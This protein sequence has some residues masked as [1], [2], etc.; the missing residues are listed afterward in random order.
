MKANIEACARHAEKVGVKVLCLGAL[1]KSEVSRM[2]RVPYSVIE[3]I[4]GC[5]HDTFAIA[6]CERL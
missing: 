3:V 6:P 5:L 2:N 4:V 1:N